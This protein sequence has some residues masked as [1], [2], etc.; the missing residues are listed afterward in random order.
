[1]SECD[2]LKGSN[3]ESCIPGA[4]LDSI[5]NYCAGLCAEYK[6]TNINYKKYSSYLINSFE[7]HPLS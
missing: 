6:C 1:M 7:N 2:I 4:N 3:D 5:M